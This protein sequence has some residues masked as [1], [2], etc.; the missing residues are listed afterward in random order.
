MLHSSPDKEPYRA[1]PSLLQLAQTTAKTPPKFCKL[2]VNLSKLFALHLGFPQAQ[3]YLGVSPSHPQACVED[4]SLK[5][6]SSPFN[7]NLPPPLQSFF[8]GFDRLGG[9]SPFTSIIF[10]LLLHLNELGVPPPDL[11]GGSS[12]TL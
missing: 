11:G 7:S 2:G 5:F 8:Y 3:V 6:I 10:L 4:C 1:F 12:T 9:D